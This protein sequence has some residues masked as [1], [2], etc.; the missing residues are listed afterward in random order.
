M[1]NKK[2]CPPLIQVHTDVNLTN[3]TGIMS[4]TH[5][6]NYRFKKQVSIP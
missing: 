2:L 5:V 3:V 1:I 6:C 4:R